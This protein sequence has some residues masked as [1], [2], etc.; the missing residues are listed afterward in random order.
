MNATVRFGRVRGIE[1]GAHWS[2][3]VIAALLAYGLTGGV[4]D[5]ALWATV[6][7]LVVVFLACL[8]AHE[9]GHSIVALR[10]GVGVRRITLWMLG[11]VA[12]LEDRMPT[13]GSTFRI[14]AAGPAVSYALA[15][16]F[17]GL[18]F[19]VAPLGPPDL[20]LQAIEWLVFVNIVLGTFNLIPAAPLDGGR[21][22]SG[23]IWAVTKDRT[24]A[25]V[26]S[27]RVG[28]ALGLA[29]IGLGLAG[30]LFHLPFFTLWTAI[31]GVFVL[32]VATAEQRYARLAGA[33]ADR[34][35]RDVMTP[36]PVTVRGWTTVQA[37]L[38]EEALAP[39]RH[40]V[41]PVVAWSG[42]IVGVLAREQ[43]QR[44]P[45]EARPSVRV[46]DVATPLAGIVVVGPEDP[47][48]DT[49]ARMDRSPMRVALV[50][51]QQVLV[52]LVTSADLAR[53]TRRPVT[54]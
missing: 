39:V 11:G 8:L 12:Q 30:T 17:L 2:V 53:T 22:L 44:V 50:F 16:L 23:A 21:I 37:F 51:E 35:V 36:E 34:R 10:N 45:V 13:A 29:F 19:A 3:L 42:E 54:I 7:P 48:L 5:A 14:A 32:R 41:L 46:Q 33:Y 43:V 26:A 49:A 4:V 15:V 27:T 6:V 18:R 28:Q 20:V 52:G 40:H 47:L 25:E 1:I 38:A 9:L 24:K 31:M